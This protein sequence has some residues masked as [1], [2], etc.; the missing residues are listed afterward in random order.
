MSKCTF[1]KK[2]LLQKLRVCV[3]GSGPA[4]FY[5]AKYLLKEGATV[6]MLEKELNPKEGVAVPEDKTK[7]QPSQMKGQYYS[8]TS[9]LFADFIGFTNLVENSDPGELLETLNIFFNGF[10]RI[11]SII[12]YIISSINY[13][14]CLNH[15]GP[16]K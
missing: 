8:V 1:A 13:K 12:I 9:I 14:V 3:V 5:T 15:S 7:E 11:I 6:H 4:G 10:D 2:G 16:R